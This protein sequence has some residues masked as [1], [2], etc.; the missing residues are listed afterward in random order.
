MKTR[1]VNILNILNEKKDWVTGKELSSI[2]DVSD[3]TIRNDIC[4]LNLE[5]K[6]IIEASVR[7]GYRLT[8]AIDK[9][10]TTNSNISVPQ[11]SDER[12]NF[13]IKKLIKSKKINLLHLQNEIYFSEFTIRNDF[14]KI[15]GGLQKYGDLK[16]KEEGNYI[17]L[18]G[19]ESN[20]RNLYKD[21]LIEETNGNF[22]NINKIDELFP[23]FNLIRIQDILGETLNDHNYLIRSE[24]FPMLIIHIGVA[25]QRM[26]DFNFVDIGNEYIDIE[27]TIEYKIAKD[28]FAKVKEVVNCEINDNEI[29]LFSRL[30]MGKKHNQFVTDGVLLKDSTQLLSKILTGIN[31]VYDI[32]FDSD[33]FFKDGLLIHLQHLLKRLNNEIQV[34]NVYL[35]EI[36][37][38]YPLV[39]EMSVFI[40]KIIEEFTGVKM[41]EDELGFLSIHLGAAYDRLNVNHHFYHTILIHTNNKSMKNLCVNKINERFGNRITIDTVMNFYEENTIKRLNPD[42][43]ISTVQMKCSLN[44]PIIMIGMFFNENDEY[45][46]FKLINDLDKKRQKQE[47][48]NQI[49]CLISNEYFLKN[50]ECD[51][52]IECIN[53]MC[54]QLYKTGKVNQYFTES[55]FLREKMAFTSFSYGYAI[56]HSLDYCTN[57]STISIATLKKPVQWGNFQ[58]KFVMLLAVR[59][60][61]KD[62]LRIFF[63]WFSNICDNSL[64]LSEIMAAKDIDELLELMTS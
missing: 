18:D 2:L 8:E 35:N 4:A 29:I 23:N 64:L 60:D 19:S 37:K 15:S 50:L 40:G 11:T 31:D 20:K 24:S 21:L 49:K 7:Y 14:K 33:E 55:T 53:I 6:G 28:F 54:N 45:T 30:L 56:P 61:D 5:C 1:Q 57:K 36:K 46:V 3:R 22:I 51:S 10:K 25:I 16:I 9:F 39:F 38:T 26:I 52:Y 34:T 62:I 12:C 27:D 47:F 32:D 63:D 13:L 41:L 44:I 42:F 48:N 17:F 43:I 58:V 59:E